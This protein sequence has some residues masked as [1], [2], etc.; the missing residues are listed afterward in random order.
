M[1][2]IIQ[3]Y[4]KIVTAM[5]HKERFI[6]TEA[7]ETDTNYR[8]QFRDDSSGVHRYIWIE[9]SKTGHYNDIE[10]V[11][12]YRLNYPN[13]PI[14]IITAKWFGKFTNVMRTFSSCLKASM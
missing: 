12:E 14:H 5:F 2:L 3:N 13:C 8:F 7:I 9:V 4:D 6:C 10:Q 1:K 11:W